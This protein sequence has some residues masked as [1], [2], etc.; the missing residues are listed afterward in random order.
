MDIKF[1][2]GQGDGLDR[3]AAEGDMTTRLSRGLHERLVRTAM[4]KVVGFAGDFF[5]DEVGEIPVGQM[6]AWVPQYLEEFEDAQSLGLFQAGGVEEKDHLLLWTL[7]R[8]FR[9]EVYVESGVFMGSSLHAFLT[10]PGLKKVLALDPNLGILKIPA[11]RV[12]GGELI[13]N[14]DFSQ[15]G[16]NFSG[17]RTLVFFDDHIDSAA[18]II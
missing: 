13:D 17:I 11:D 7:G 16:I 12:P 15:L 6:D 3:Q 4:T 5:G 10:C 9:P 1:I 14:Q 18:R 2:M 8:V